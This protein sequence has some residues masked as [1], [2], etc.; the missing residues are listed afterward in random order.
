MLLSHID[1]VKKIL[2][3]NALDEELKEKMVNILIHLPL[4][5]LP[6]LF[7]IISTKEITQLQQDLKDVMKALENETKGI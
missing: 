3:D 4:E 5:D 6:E 7:K 1:I 2:E